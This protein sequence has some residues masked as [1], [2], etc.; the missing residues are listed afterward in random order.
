MMKNIKEINSRLNIRVSSLVV[1]SIIGICLLVLLIPISCKAKETITDDNAKI[2][3]AIDESVWKEEPIN[4][5]AEYLNRKW[6]NDCGAL[7]ISSADIY[8]VLEY[9]EF[10]GLSREYFNYK[11]LL[12]N[13][14][15]AK[16]VIDSFEE[17]LPISNWKYKEYNMKFVEFSGAKKESDIDIYYTMYLT[18]NNGYIFMVQYMSTEP[19][20]TEVCEASISDVVSSVKSTI[21]VKL[22]NDEPENDESNFIFVFILSAILTFICY[23]AYPFI[24]IKIMKKQYQE[25]EAMKMILWNSIIVGIVLLITLVYIDENATYSAGPSVLY[26]FINKYL[27]VKKKDNIEEI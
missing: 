26:Y 21:P 18:I 6:T 4:N 22:A 17:T 15:D 14:D 23:T 10:E 25:K 7:M 1:Y 11:N 27:W 9:S 8:D 5:D 24:R 2:E 12:R 13:D 20:K 3:F 16:I 19:T